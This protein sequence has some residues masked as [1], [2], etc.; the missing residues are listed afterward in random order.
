MKITDFG[1][2][3]NGDETKLYTLTN[4]NNMEISVTDYGAALTQ[5]IV[6]DK[7][8][9]LCDVVLGYDEAAEYEAGGLF[10]GATVGRSAN[11]IGGA[12]IEINGK[13]YEL[14]KNDNDNNQ[15][16]LPISI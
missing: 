1:A 6:P 10:L 12:S 8:G 3:V 9:N 15:T 4:C 13:I 2:T 5:V 14:V 11:R 16:A 7:E